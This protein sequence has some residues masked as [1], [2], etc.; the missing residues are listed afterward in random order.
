MNP[1][2]ANVCPLRSMLLPAFQKTCDAPVNDLSHY[3]GAPPYPFIAAFD[4]EKTEVLIDGDGDLCLLPTYDMA[5]VMHDDGYGLCCLYFDEHWNCRI[6][7]ESECDAVE[8]SL[9]RS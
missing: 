6:A 1:D 7:F 9:R 5:E 4:V 2:D 8:F 3:P